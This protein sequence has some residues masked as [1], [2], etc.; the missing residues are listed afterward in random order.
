[1]GFY[2]FVFFLAVVN[3]DPK[4]EMRRMNSAGMSIVQIQKIDWKIK[5]TLGVQDYC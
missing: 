4:P 2:F 1:M 5:I 3:S